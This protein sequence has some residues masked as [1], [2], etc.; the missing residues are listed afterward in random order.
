MENTNSVGR[1]AVVKTDTAPAAMGT[2]GCPGLAGDESEV[3]LW[4]SGTNRPEIVVPPNA[5]D[6]HWHIF[7]TTFPIASYAT[8][9]PPPA[10]LKAYFALRDR[11]G[12]SRGVLVQPSTYGTDNRAYL[13]VMNEIGTKNYRM[14]AVVNTSVTDSDLIN[15]H[16][17]GVRGIRF[18]LA[19]AGATSIEMLEP[20]SRRVSELGWHCQIQMPGEKIAEAQDVFNRLGGTLV[21][22]HVARIGQML[23]GNSATYKVIRRLL[24]GGR[25]WVKL[26]APYIDSKLGAPDYLDVGKVASQLVR[27]APERMVWGSDWPHA[28]EPENAKPNDASIM[29]LLAMWAPDEKIRNRILVDNPAQLYGFSS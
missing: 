26:S 9:K 27:A 1:R 13:R 2:T 16:E 18:N 23:G 29:D 19:Q 21:F 15:M 5:T 11:L 28:T 12:L 10:S 20:L 22:D 14:I 17:C 6:C 3:D 25:T 7:D 24:D 4:T 8:L